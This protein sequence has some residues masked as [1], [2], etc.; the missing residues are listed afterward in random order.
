ME[1]LILRAGSKV[2]HELLAV[3]AR[4]LSKLEVHLAPDADEGSL[5]GAPNLYCTPHN[6]WYS[7]ES[8]HEMRR[9]GQ[10]ILHKDGT[11]VTQREMDGPWTIDPSWW[12]SADGATP[13]VDGD[14]LHNG[15][16]FAS[17]FRSTVHTLVPR[18]CLARWLSWNY[19][20]TSHD[21]RRISARP[22]TLLWCSMNSGPACV[23]FG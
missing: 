20:W 10:P 1:P 19:V 22:A 11:P 18:R 15:I 3:H 9:K 5:A 4:L 6:A 2:E 21:S 13:G 12:T 7:P 16:R 8:R 17:H 23:D 14:F